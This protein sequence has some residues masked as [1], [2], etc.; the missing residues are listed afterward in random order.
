MQLLPDGKTF[1]YRQTKE[2]KEGS[3]CSPVIIQVINW[4]F[5]GG[6][7][8][9][10]F[11]DNDRA[12]ACYNWAATDFP[13]ATHPPLGDDPKKPTREM[14]WQIAAYSATMVRT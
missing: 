1:T 6:A 3:F 10:K 12:N 14:T 11:D 7:K 5:M 4:S 2:D 13:P 8:G 9:I